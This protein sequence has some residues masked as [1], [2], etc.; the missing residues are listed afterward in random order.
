M[1]IKSEFGEKKISK[2]LK[3]LRQSLNEKSEPWE[4]V[5]WKSQNLGG[6]FE[7]KKVRT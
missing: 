3:N 6:K 4:K 1:G 2:N 7:K 5:H